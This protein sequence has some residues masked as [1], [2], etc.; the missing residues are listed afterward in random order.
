LPAEAKERAENVA[1]PETALA[2]NVPLTPEGADE[3][4]T[5]AVEDVTGLPLASSI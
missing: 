3:M 4:V 2:V 5:D 1:T